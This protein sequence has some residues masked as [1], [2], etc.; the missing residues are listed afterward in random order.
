[1]IVTGQVNQ[2]GV[3]RFAPGERA[4]LVRAIFK[5]GNFGK[6]ARREAVRYVR[7]EEDGGRTVKTVDVHKIIE[8]GLLD[9]DMDV[10][11]G[12]MVI[13]DPMPG[14]LYVYGAVKT[15]GKVA[16]PEVGEL[17]TLQALAEVGGV[18]QYAAPQEAYVLRGKTPGEPPERIKVDLV[19]AFENIGGPENM[20]LRA[21]DVFFV[22]AITGPINA[23]LSS[24]AIEVIVTGEV[25]R[26]GLVAFAP[27]EQCSFVR[28]IFKAGNFTRYAKTESVRWVRY[29]RDGTREAKEIDAER[30]VGEGRLDEDFQLQ[31][32]DMIIVPQKRFNF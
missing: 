20:K 2:P 3:V 7:Y 11:S 6:H 8:E 9:T 13:V 15:P 21:N 28:A 4:T 19:K 18:S 27:G 30:M 16:M 31:S 17:T 12:D 24:Q 23:I 25:G 26:P 22:P 1:V 14:S 29:G 32:G 10:G 5:A